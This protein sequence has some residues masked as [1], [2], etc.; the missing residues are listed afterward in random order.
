MQQAPNNPSEDI[1]VICK[2]G[3]NFG[4]TPVFCRVGAKDGYMC[5]GSSGLT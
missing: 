2:P 4:L 1:L 3:L 5:R